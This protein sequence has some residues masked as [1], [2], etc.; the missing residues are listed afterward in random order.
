MDYNSE[1][2]KEQ[3]VINTLRQRLR[4][5]VQPQKTVHYQIQN[6][7]YGFRNDAPRRMIVRR[8]KLNLNNGISNS[9]KKILFF[10]NAMLGE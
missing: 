5:L 9:N 1:I 8:Q 4:L 7:R 2:I 10:R 6:M 3:G